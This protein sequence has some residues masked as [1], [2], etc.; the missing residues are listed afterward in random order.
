[1]EQSLVRSYSGRGGTTYRPEISYSYTVAGEYYSGHYLGD[2]CAS[3]EEVD[4]FVGRFCKGT[5]L[6]VHVHPRKPDLSVLRV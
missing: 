3:E 2:L 4:Q 1:M 5:A 6:Q